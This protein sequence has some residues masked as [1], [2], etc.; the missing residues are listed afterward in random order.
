MSF[1][2]YIEN[3]EQETE[4]LCQEVTN[5]NK[6]KEKMEQEEAKLVCE[7]MPAFTEALQ[8]LEADRHFLC[9]VSDVPSP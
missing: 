1:S 3:I 2:E 4:E 5:S 9:S 6:D 7:P 8:C